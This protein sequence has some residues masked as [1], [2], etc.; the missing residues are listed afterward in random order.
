MEK[1]DDVFEAAL[2]GKRVP[3]LTLDHKWYKLFSKM[4]DIPEIEQYTAELN[5]LIKKQGKYNTD[6][7]DIRALKKKLMNEVMPLAQ[8][9]KTDPDRM[10]IRKMD[11]MT[12]LIEECN[13]KLD[14]AREQ[15][16]ELPIQMDEVNRKLM[17]LTMRVCYQKLQQ[18]TGEIAEI[19]DWIEKMRDE[20]KQNVVHKQEMEIENQ[21][22]YTYMHNIFGPDVIDL[23]DM[24]YVPEPKKKSLKMETREDEKAKEDPEEHQENLNGTGA[25][26]PEFQEEDRTIKI[27]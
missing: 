3:Y 12:R 5:E 14:E 10:T 17:L 26:A 19:T 2:A 21:K 4:E 24:K 8:K 9:M 16:A 20:L 7:K 27:W 25:E 1:K 6:L 22:I 13:Q 15:A 18:N 11:E 23:F